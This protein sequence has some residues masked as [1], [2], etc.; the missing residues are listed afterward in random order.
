MHPL[1]RGVVDVG[2]DQ[3]SVVEE[4]GQPVGIVVDV[5]L[6]LAVVGEIAGEVVAERCSVNPDELVASGSVGILRYVDPIGLG[7]AVVVGIVG[8]LTTGT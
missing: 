5:G 6:A 1:P 3:D 4:L 2:G 7:Q 8:I